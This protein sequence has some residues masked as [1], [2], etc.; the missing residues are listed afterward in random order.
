MADAAPEVGEVAADSGEASR[1]N[2]GQNGAVVDTS[3]APSTPV[4]I[5]TDGNPNDNNDNM[6]I[7]DQPVNVTFFKGGSKK[8]YSGMLIRQIK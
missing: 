3:S 7:N 8:Y 4:E 6:V 1:T 5:E 2:P